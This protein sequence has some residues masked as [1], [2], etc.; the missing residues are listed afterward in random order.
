MAVWFQI[1]EKTKFWGIMTFSFEDFDMW[2]APGWR[3]GIQGDQ[4]L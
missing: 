2:H 1:L 4:Q 3:S